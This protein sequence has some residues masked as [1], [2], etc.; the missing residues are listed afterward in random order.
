MFLST[1]QNISAEHLTDFVS[2]ISNID[3]FFQVGT[4]K[5]AHEA[6][7]KLLDIFDTGIS[8]FLP[9][10]AGINDTFFQGIYK[11]VKYCTNCKNTA[12]NFEHFFHIRVFPTN[13]GINTAIANAFRDETFDFHCANCN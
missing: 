1:L 10:Q 5:D 11:I 13:I 8:A 12:L 4:Q 9:N 7:L 2:I 6:L 3:N